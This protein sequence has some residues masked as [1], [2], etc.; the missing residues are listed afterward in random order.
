MKNWAIK[1]GLKH[2]AIKIVY[3]V[4]CASLSIQHAILRNLQ[5]KAFGDDDE[6]TDIYDPPSLA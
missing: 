6:K 5:R 1:A 3:E 2:W 4:D